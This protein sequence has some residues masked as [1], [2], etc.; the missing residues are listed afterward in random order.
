MRDAEWLVFGAALDPLDAPE[1][2]EMK[3][4]YL[5]AVGRGIL[6]PAHPRDPY[7]LISLQIE[8]IDA[9]RISRAGKLEV[10]DWLRPRPAPR[11]LPS[12]R[13]ERFTAFLDDDGC[14]RYASLVSDFVQA[15]VLP[16]RPLMIG[17]DHS[18]TGGVLRSLAG[19]HGPEQLAVVVLDAHSDILPLSRRL[20]LYRLLAGE[21]R[22]EEVAGGQG[23]NATRAVPDSYNCGSFLHFLVEEGV[24]E[25]TNLLL[26]GVADQPSP[27][28][29]AVE[30][31][32]APALRAPFT[33]LEEAGAVFLAKRELAG[34][35]GM[36]RLR[37]A[38]D[39]FADRVVYVSLDIDVGALEAARACRFM[40][41][42]GLAERE[43]L[44]ICDVVGGWLREREGRLAGLDLMEMDVHLAG[45]R[46]RDGTRDQTARLAARMLSKL[47]R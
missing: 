45:L 14:R 19:V 9:G 25:P 4:A 29:G 15:E 6:K 20:E 13:Q 44:A 3:K 11:S 23:A 16:R 34:T 8:E 31:A 33:E 7:D 17:V 28:P 21:G 38:L 12:L 2:V 10:E 37:Q 47:L 30:G 41:L 42:F 5:Q 22:G 39:R 24:V 35:G 43:L 1:K 32:A 46:H 26:V 27:P 18:L 36:A 40:D